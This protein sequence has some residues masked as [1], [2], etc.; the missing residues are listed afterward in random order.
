VLHTGI[1]GLIVVKSGGRSPGGILALP[2]LAVLSRQ[3]GLVPDPGI[4]EPNKIFV[5]FVNC[6]A[7]GYSAGRVS[8]SIINADSLAGNNRTGNLETGGI[9]QAFAHATSSFDR[10]SVFGGI[11]P[12]TQGGGKQHKQ[13]G[14]GSTVHGAV[15]CN[16]TCRMV[17]HYES[18]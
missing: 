11:A 8:A 13:Y 14:E 6:E 12:E 1:R 9:G 15:E 3:A 5:G 4:V 2:T 16:E 17:Q 7:S 10:R 18:W